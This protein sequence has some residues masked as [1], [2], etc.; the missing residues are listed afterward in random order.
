MDRVIKVKSFLENNRLASLATVSGRSKDPQI[1]IIYYVYDNG[2]LYFTT[3]RSSQK[4]KN[5]LKNKKLA[6]AI[7]QENQLELLQIE[8]TGEIVDDSE[9]RTTTIQKIYDKLSKNDTHEP[10]PVLKLHPKHIEVF[11]VTIDRFKYSNFAGE[12]VVLEGTAE[13]LKSDFRQL[14]NSARERSSRHPR[15]VPHIKRR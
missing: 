2:I 13:D 1:A 12:V 8:G 11:E 10:W 15:F 14:E 9:E 6:L 3:E 4:A 7:V 5:I